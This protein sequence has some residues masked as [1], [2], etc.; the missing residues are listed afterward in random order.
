MSFLFASPEH[1]GLD[2]KVTRIVTDKTILDSA[3]KT[4]KVDCYVYQVGSQFFQSL[5]VLSEIKSLRISGRTTR[6]LKVKEVESALAEPKGNAEE[7][8]L[9]DVWIDSMSPTESEIKQKI[10]E[11]IRK[12]PRDRKAYVTEDTG[13]TLIE[14][15]LQDAL[16]G[17]LKP[18]DFFLTDSCSER[19][20]QSKDRAE[21]AK[22]SDSLLAVP[23]S[24]S[25]ATSLSIDPSRNSEQSEPK[26]PP[27]P[28]FPNRKFTSR[29]QY[30]IVFKE[31]CQ[32]L[33][34]LRSWKETAVAITGALY[35]T[36]GRFKHMYFR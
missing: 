13:N 31:V 8:V 5:E 24:V 14:R 22:L 23:G 30:C 32:A 6:V 10:L 27:T 7:M 19:G 11:D 2:P 29:R 17:P 15:L 36:W 12:I 18:E 16:N 20:I 25:R 34:E 35:G 9:K 26:A 3:N 33:H 21:N 4:K 28:R 1:L